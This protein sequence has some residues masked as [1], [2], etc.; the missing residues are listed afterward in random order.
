MSLFNKLRKKEK[1]T[2]SEVK[3]G[4]NK[5]DNK[6]STP[7]TK[8]KEGE[9]RLE[10]KYSKL[11]IFNDGKKR[12]I[13]INQDYNECIEFDKYIDDL[14][15][16]N[17]IL[18]KDN[19]YALCYLD[20][21][22]NEFVITDFKFVSYNVVNEYAMSL[23]DAN[24]SYCYYI[25][26]AYFEDVIEATNYT[27]GYDEFLLI[28]YSD[29]SELYLYNSKNSKTRLEFVHTAKSF[30]FLH[31][32]DSKINSDAIVKY[33]KENGKVSYLEIFRGNDVTDCPARFEFNSLEFVETKLAFV[34]IA[35]DSV[36]TKFFFN[37]N[38]PKKHSNGYD[39]IKVVND[40]FLCIRG[41]TLE[42]VDI[43]TNILYSNTFDNISN[44]N[45][46]YL[47]KKDE[48]VLYSDSGEFL[49]LSID[50]KANYIKNY[51][52]SI[53]SHATKSGALYVTHCNFTKENFIQ[54]SL[55]G[56]GAKIFE[57]EDCYLYIPTYHISKIY[58][59]SKYAPFDEVVNHE[60]D[61]YIKHVNNILVFDSNYNELVEITNLYIDLLKKC[62]IQDIRNINIDDHIITIEALAKVGEITISRDT[63]TLKVDD[64]QALFFKFKDITT[65][66]TDY[67][68]EHIKNKFILALVK[69]KL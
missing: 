3:K 19:L 23:K 40:L 28:K 69:D 49:T 31:I 57:F 24:N 9:L 46:F 44:M 48:Y 37:L 47:V 39:K 55:C 5:V 16:G 60:F 52:Y 29:H 45:L 17:L 1:I 15:F 66:L 35:T 8:Y 34:F 14:P 26:N 62:D 6:K 43:F 36:G 64:C 22:F 10:E 61:E 59:I 38:T 58:F 7:D 18:K 33:E 12:Y 56:H 32:N 27:A 67:A 21:E 54:S 13:C 20:R 25:A 11:S 4:T 68:L 53:Y 63:M 65:N 30:E 41:T 51:S 42:I 50:C 2:E